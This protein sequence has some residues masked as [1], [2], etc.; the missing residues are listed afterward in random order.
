MQPTTSSASSHAGFIMIGILLPSHILFLR[1]TQLDKLVFFCSDSD[2][3]R[4][5]FKFEEENAEKDTE[6]VKKER[7]AAVMGMMQVSR[8]SNSTKLSILSS[9]EC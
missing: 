7:F 1:N 5:C 6:A 9:T 3:L 4:I 2:C 8:E